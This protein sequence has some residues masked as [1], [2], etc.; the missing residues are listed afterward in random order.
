MFFG[1]LG[2]N[3]AGFFETSFRIVCNRKKT[4]A[5]LL[6]LVV[7]VFGFVTYFF[8][9]QNFEFN[10]GYVYENIVND[11][12]EEPTIEIVKDTRNES[13][14]NVENFVYLP[15][16]SQFKIEV[17]RQMNCVT[18][19]TYD[20]N[21]YYN[22]PVKAMVCSTGKAGDETPLGEYTLGDKSVWCLLV[23]STWGQ[24][25]FRINGPIMFHSVPYYEL[26]KDTLEVE[27]YNKLGEPASLGCIRLSVE[28]AKWLY[29]NCDD[30]TQVLIYDSNDPGPLGKPVSEE[31]INDIGWDPTDPDDNN[32][33]N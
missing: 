4:F 16:Q 19:Y 8:Y 14:I 29:D 21:G 7:L 22:K 11:I 2:A 26:S 30:R 5:T 6:G 13:S 3:I 23:N 31:I 17:N 20:E 18:I 9:L 15:K 28:D 12:Y 27:E 1:I 24:Y 33:Y 10:D 32:P 25:A